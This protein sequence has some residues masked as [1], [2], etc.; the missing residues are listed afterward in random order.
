MPGTTPLYNAKLQSSLDLNNKGLTGNNAAKRFIFKEI[1]ATGK[2]IDVSDMGRLLRFSGNRIITLNNNIAGVTAGDT[3]T[4]TTDSSIDWNGTANIFNSFYDSY[5]NS[6]IQFIYTG[7][8]NWFVI[9]S[10]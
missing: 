7:S 5:S 4:A 3:F 1:G 8:N 9:N 10:N 6:I 2:V